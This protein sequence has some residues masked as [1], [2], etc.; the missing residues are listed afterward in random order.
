MWT[1]RDLRFAAWTW[2]LWA[3]CAAGAQVYSS[4]GVNTPIPDAGVLSSV[5]HVEAGPG[6][7]GTLRVRV[8]LEHSW[9]ADLDLAIIPP[10][11]TAYL[12]LASDLGGSG[13]GFDATTFDGA[14]SKSI[15]EAGAPFAG[16]YRPEGGPMIWNFGPGLPGLALDQLQDLSGG[17]A[18][19]DWT[20]LVADDFLGETGT[21][22]E[23]ALMFSGP[24][25]PSPMQAALTLSPG[26]AGPGASVVA[27]LRVQFGQF[28]L[29]TGVVA[30]LDATAVGAGVV[31]LADDGVA[32]DESAGDRT[33][34]G[35]LAIGGSAP[36]GPAALVFAAADAQL[37][38]ATGSAVVTVLPAPA[39]NDRCEEAVEIG[40]GALPYVAPAQPAA[41]NSVDC[42]HPLACAAGGGENA[43]RSV[44]YR[45][46]CEQSGAYLVSTSQARAPGCTV[47]DTVLGVYESQAG[48]CAAL[49]PLA[50][51]DDSGSGKAAELEINLAAGGVYYVQVAEW[52][53]G[54]GAA[55]ELSV[56][57]ERSVVVGACCTVTGC[58]RVTADECAAVGGSYLGDGI[59][60]A[61]G[62][63]LVLE[64][65][66]YA[67]EDIAQS[68]AVLLLGDDASVPVHLGFEFGFLG[69][70]YT[71]CNVGSNGLITFGSASTT[72]LNTAIPS[73]APPNAAVYALWDD[74]DPGAGGD[75][76][77]EVRG[78]AGVDLR[79]IVQWSMVPQ[80]GFG[81]ANTFQVVLME[82]GS[83]FLS[84]GVIS[85][86]SD[87]D[88]TIGVESADGTIA[89]S[90]PASLVVT[91]TTLRLWTAPGV[92]SCAVCAWAVDGCGAD[93]TND[94][95]VDGDDVIAFFGDWDGGVTCADVDLSGSVDGDDVIWFFQRW[96]S[97]G[98]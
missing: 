57:F 27:E 83:A 49:I 67:F 76:R 89:L 46:V 52:A 85:A 87:G 44:W 6:S 37:R 41:G 3:V 14:A 8:R 96:D 79:L 60:C 17:P 81:D 31:P 59:G 28:P 95:A 90:R 25:A 19:G 61:P 5:I 97:G 56:S 34:T 4:G 94:E 20:L 2:P 98:C 72:Y 51:D 73:A 74:L 88:A 63:G 22:V 54:G 86:F 43:A 75:V 65:A 32:P 36:P 91:G 80:H 64:G 77:F 12:H 93:Y 78:A 66:A 24:G 82:G 42:E 30:S 92:A 35:Q 53:P 38:T 16:T 71:A 40:Q 29:S 84:Y 68:G 58:A 15:R 26:A 18:D 13:D 62:S 33:F 21:L 39:V 7:I 50:C 70:S 69:G 10:G 47:A 11:A 23:W 1:S 9:D 48:D 55:G 45:F